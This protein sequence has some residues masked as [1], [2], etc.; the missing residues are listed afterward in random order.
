MRS[1]MLCVALAL[2]P[3]QG[4]AQDKANPKDDEATAPLVKSLKSAKKASDKIAAIGKLAD[5]GEKARP[6]A[7]AVAEML[8]DPMEAVRVAA[9]DAMEKIDPE[10]HKLLVIYVFDA[11]QTKKS[12]ALAELA[13]IKA[14]AVLPILW[15]RM[16]MPTDP[17]VF[18]TIVAID[19]A[20]PRVVEEVLR[21]VSLPAAAGTDSGERNTYF[22]RSGL[23]HLDAVET[24]TAK[25]VAALT[26]A[27]VDKQ[28]RVTVI[29]SLAKFGPDA[30]AALPAILKYKLDGDAKVRDAV[31]KAVEEIGAK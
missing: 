31:A 16:A 9:A 29:E 19:P 11:D 30:K 6:A 4:V 3:S 18:D 22:R 24:T 21:R 5:L 27:L 25:R 15:R 20:D 12:M 7:D 1:V 2:L 8:I 14:K 13:K 10:V 23:K 17:I 26:A 28:T